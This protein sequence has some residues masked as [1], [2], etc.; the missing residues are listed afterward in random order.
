MRRIGAGSTADY[1]LFHPFF[2]RDFRQRSAIV[3]LVTANPPFFDPLFLHVR[4]STLRANKHAFD[5]MYFP[6]FF[7]AP[8]PGLSWPR[9]A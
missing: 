8:L 3:T 4:L 7:H 6:R 1:F 5:V 9:M 2:N